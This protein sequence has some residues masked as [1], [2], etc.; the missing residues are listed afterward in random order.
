[1]FQPKYTKLLISFLFASIYSHVAISA[2]PPKYIDPSFKI[3]ETTKIPLP[4]IDLSGYSGDELVLL[5]DILYE[6]NYIKFQSVFNNLNKT[7]Q[8]KISY[9]VAQQ[10]KGH[11]PLYW[12]MADLYA[13]TKQPL[14]AHKWL[15][16]S[17][18]MTSQDAALCADRTANY[19]TQKLLRTF[20]H[21]AD[22]TRKTPKYINPAMVEVMSFMENLQ[23]RTNPE[24][25][26][27][28][29][30]QPVDA[31]QPKLIEKRDWARIRSDIYNK[32]TSKYKNIK[33]THPLDF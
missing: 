8:D 33:T 3:I 20:S 18:I 10:N 26:C 14:Q 29:G 32:Y 6:Q 23:T 7:D 13:K 16:V 25:V 17:T 1:M 2:T 21:A 12:L 30:T 31:D 11:T 19:A 15:Y 4:T 27:K 9:L 5:S 28:L 24:W 22:L